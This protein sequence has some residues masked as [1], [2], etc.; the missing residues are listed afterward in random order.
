M[1]KNF[2]TIPFIILFISMY[3]NIGLAQDGIGPKM[4]IGQTEYD[5]K[6]VKQGEIINHTFKILNTGDQVLEI[7]NVKPG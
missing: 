5:A 6:E 3:L 4:V 2:Y 7:K 1:K